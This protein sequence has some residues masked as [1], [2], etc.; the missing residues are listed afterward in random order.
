MFRHIAMN[1]DDATILHREIN[2]IPLTS[3]LVLMS[4]KPNFRSWLAPPRRIAF[5]ACERKIAGSSVST[6]FLALPRIPSSA[7]ICLTCPRP[8]A[9]AGMRRA[10]IA[11]EES[12]KIRNSGCLRLREFKLSGVAVATA[13]A[14]SMNDRIA[15]VAVCTQSMQSREKR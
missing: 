14:S 1:I 4:H 15:G 5:R 2:L 12:N 7:F 13:A 6:P 11:S 8:P 10:C 3:A 9:V